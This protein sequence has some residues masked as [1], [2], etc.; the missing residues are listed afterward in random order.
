MHKSKEKNKEGKDC[1]FTTSIV[2][3]QMFKLHK[4]EQEVKK[5]AQV[6]IITNLL[7]QTKSINRPTTFLADLDWLPWSD[8]KRHCLSIFIA[9]WFLQLDSASIQHDKRAATRVFSS[10][11]PN[12]NLLIRNSRTPREM[13]C[14]AFVNLSS[15]LEEARSFSSMNKASSFLCL[16]SYASEFLNI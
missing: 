7:R 3:L 13:R 11:L 6:E 12:S 10:K 9:I 2:H 1:L 4:V 5:A 14:L 16:E 15:L 8:S